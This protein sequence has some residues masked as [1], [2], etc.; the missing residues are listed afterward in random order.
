MNLAPE[1]QTLFSAAKRLIEEGHPVIAIAVDR[2][3]VSTVDDLRRNLGLDRPLAEVFGIGPARNKVSSSSTHSMQPAE[4][5]RSRFPGMIRLVL[6]QAQNW[7]VVA[8]IRVFDL[9]FGVIYRE[10]FKGRTST[11]VTKIQSFVRSGTYP[12]QS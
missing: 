11:S 10:L 7:H 8:S 12:F 9:K 5:R 2:H 1:S 6:E 4:V 3:P